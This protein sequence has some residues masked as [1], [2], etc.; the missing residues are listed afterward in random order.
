[1]HALTAAVLFSLLLANVAAAGDPTLVGWWKCDEGAG[2]TAHDS[3]G[4]GND[5]AFNG[6]PQWVEGYFGAGV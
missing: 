5:G 2:T 3:G 6:D 1:M 4:Y